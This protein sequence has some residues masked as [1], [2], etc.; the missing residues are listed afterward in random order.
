MPAVAYRAQR[1]GAEYA[2]L[3]HRDVV[4]GQ[5]TPEKLYGFH[6]PPVRGAADGAD[7][8]FRQLDETA[9]PEDLLYLTGWLFL[10]DEQV[11]GVGTQVDD[12]VSVHLP[13]V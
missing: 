9:L 11:E 6:T 1:G 2:Y 13:V 5:N 3:I 12:S 7:A 4:G 8:L 10:C